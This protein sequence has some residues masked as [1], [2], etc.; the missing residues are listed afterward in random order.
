MKRILLLLIPFLLLSCEEQYSG[1]FD[2]SGYCYD[3][4]SDIPLSNFHIEYRHWDAYFETYTDANGYFELNGSYHFS[5]KEYNLPGSGSYLISDNAGTYGR[6]GSFRMDEETEFE[7]DTIYFYH[8]VNSVYTVKMDS[9]L[10][11]GNLD[12]I[13]FNF[14]ENCS[15]QTLPIYTSYHDTDSSRLWF[16]V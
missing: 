5:Y 16:C 14:T 13:F 15:D 3:P 8:K 12:T 1:D 6:C 11:T 4:C 10:S 2:I 7:N 9:S